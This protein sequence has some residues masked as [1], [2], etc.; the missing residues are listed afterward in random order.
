M[1]I[2]VNNGTLMS[3]IKNGT[4]M[5]QI[6][7]IKKDKK[8]ILNLNKSASSAFLFIQRYQRHQRSNKE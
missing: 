4:L 6:N 3:I 7:M 1:M 2:A 8:I 5:T